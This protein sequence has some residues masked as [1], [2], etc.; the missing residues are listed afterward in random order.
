MNYK[1]YQTDPRTCDYCFEWW[2]W[3]QDRFNF[4]RD[5]KE[6]YSGTVVPNEDGPKATLED[7]YQKFNIDHP[8]DFK[9]HS[10]SVSDVVELDG[11][12]YYCDNV[13]WLD[14]TKFIK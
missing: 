3:A 10:L 11:K 8:A 14:I 1:I 7:L 9:G 2:S 4:K 12:F 6:V 13:G 5:Y